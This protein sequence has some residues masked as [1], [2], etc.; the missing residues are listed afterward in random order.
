V[1]ASSAGR[2]ET[3]DQQ[4]GMRPSRVGGGSDGGAANYHDA[5]VNYDHQEWDSFVAGVGEGMF[6]RIAA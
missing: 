1:P 6:T 4:I 3:K 2:S 5:A